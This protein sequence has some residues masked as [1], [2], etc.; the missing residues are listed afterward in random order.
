VILKYRGR[1]S[2]QAGQAGTYQ[3]FFSVNIENKGGGQWAVT[4]YMPFN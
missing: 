4:K 2:N 1:R 3:D